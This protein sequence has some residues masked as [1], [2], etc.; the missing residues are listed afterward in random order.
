MAD[1]S[2]VFLFILSFLAVSVSSVEVCTKLDD[3]SC[4]KSNGKKISLR[5][6]DGKPGP[7]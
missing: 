2:V 6:I 5:N 4:K 1:G 3:C 7:K